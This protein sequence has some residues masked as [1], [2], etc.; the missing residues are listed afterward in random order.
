MNLS[1]TKDVYFLRLLVCGLS[2]HRSM[3]DLGPVLVRFVE[4]KLAERQ[5]SLGAVQFSPVISSLCS[6]LLYSSLLNFIYYYSY[7]KEKREKLRNPQ[8]NGHS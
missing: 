6:S 5:V 3:L 8:T 7:R 4:E 1:L 2:P